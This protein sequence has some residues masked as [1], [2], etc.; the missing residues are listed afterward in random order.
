MKSLSPVVVV[1]SV[2]L[3]A[4]AGVGAAHRSRLQ[5]G[6]P[7]VNAW[8]SAEP[9]EA[10]ELP[11][12]APGGPPLVPHR[13]D[14]MSVSREGND[15]LGCHLET[16]PASHAFNEYKKE[17]KAG[18]VTGMRWQCLQCHSPQTSAEAP[19]ATRRP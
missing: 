13:V 8:T 9:G 2:G 4:A 7:G 18:E 12:W 5:K 11:H 6:A 1:L 14:G 15:C 17:R 10:P 16:I 19:V 3:A